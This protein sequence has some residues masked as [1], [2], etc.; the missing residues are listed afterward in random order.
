MVIGEDRMSSLT[1][2]SI[3]NLKEWMR[4]AILTTNEDAINH[5][6]EICTGYGING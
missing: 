2:P 6:K 4:Q 3:P 5:P 1:V